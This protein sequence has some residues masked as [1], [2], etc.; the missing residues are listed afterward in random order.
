MLTCVVDWPAGNT[1]VQAPD[2]MMAALKRPRASG[3]THR[4]HTDWLPCWSPN[5]V[6]RAASPPN[7]AMLACNVVSQIQVSE[8][9]NAVSQIQVSEA[10][11]Q[12]H[13][14]RYQRPAMQ[15]HKYH[16]YSLRFKVLY[17]RIW[18]PRSGLGTCFGWDP[19]TKGT[20]GK[21]AGI[22]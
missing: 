6:T 20:K 14:Y 1:D 10:S 11:M 9:C 5:T 2:S 12:Y 8:A 15:Y 18:T 4:M 13:K 21:C 19:G 22:R 3:E 17:G 7:H 16:K